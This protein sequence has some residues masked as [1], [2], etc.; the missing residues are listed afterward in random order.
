M[1]IVISRT[2]VLAISYKVVDMQN[3]IVGALLGKATKFISSD[4]AVFEKMCLKIIG[5]S[6]KLTGFRVSHTSEELTLELIPEFMC[7]LLEIYGSIGV[8][9]YG[10][11]KQAD[12]QF[13]KKKKKW[14]NK[15][16]KEIY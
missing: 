2:E 13:K 7:D 1:K 8:A 11:T 14:G 4:S 10:L 6:D 9:F 16:W 5:A 12:S 3:N 15:K